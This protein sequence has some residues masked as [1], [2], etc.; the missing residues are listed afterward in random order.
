[1]KFKS[2]LNVGKC[3]TFGL[4]V[5]SSSVKIIALSRGAGG[6]TVTG[7]GMADVT[8]S[9]IA[10][11]R[12]ANQVQAI[13]DCLRM[14]G[15]KTRLAVC[16]VGGPD[17][18]V[19]DFE[20]PG[21]APEEIEGA[22]TL[23]ASQVCPFKI[24]GGALDY[25][26]LPESSGKVRGVL[27]AATNSLI[28]SRVWLAKESSL[29]SVLMDV[30]SLALL[31]CFGEL[32]EPDGG[33]STAILNVGSLYS[34]LAVVGDDGRPFI[35]DINHAGEHI[36]GQLCH[37]SGLLPEQV[38]ERLFVDAADNSPG[39]GFDMARSCD[40]LVAD[41]IKTSRYYKTQFG[42]ACCKRMLVCG[43]FARAAG[44]VELL[45]S[46]LPT[47][48]VLWNPFK[49]MRW[50][51]GSSQKVILSRNGPAFV[52]AAGLAMRSI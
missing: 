35:R 17:V 43:G 16:S 50:D 45:Q 11:D 52:I 19:R 39:P 15:I 47:E 33:V 48:V 31:N 26:L 23:E 13:Q 3:Q 40:S 44:F 46:K 29:T 8:P 1:M 7:A 24:E 36:L 4:D 28:E 14:A 32:E 9:E 38:V 21:L 22:V 6:Y 5:G 27:V 12:R 37:E 25:E 30:D 51:I 49:K 10:S 20:F 41:V 18:A 42:S 34:T 2:L